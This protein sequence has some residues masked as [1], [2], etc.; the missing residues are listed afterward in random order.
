VNEDSFIKE[1]GRSYIVSSFLP[2]AFFI[3]LLFLLFRVFIPKGFTALVL[4]QW[5]LVSVF[6]IWI[7]FFLFSSVDWIV[8]LFE[9]YHFHPILKKYL[10]NRYSSQLKKQALSYFETQGV[11]RKPVEKRTKKD[12]KIFSENW[13]SAMGELQE[14]ELETSLED[15]V[16]MPTRLGNVMKA[17]E[18]YA[19]DRY[20]IEAITIWPR[21]FS[22]LPSG[23]IKDMEEK[24]NHF[25]FL[26]NS[27]LLIY[28][29][30]GFCLLAAFLGF[31]YQACKYPLFCSTLH[32]L[33]SLQ[34]GFDE[35][36]PLMYLLICA[37]LIYF[38]Y[39]LYRIA[40]NAAQD[41]GLF[42]R[43]GFDLYRME[44]LKQLHRKLPQDLGD[45]R[46]TW[47]ALSTFFISGDRLIWDIEKIKYP[48]Y[49]YHK[50]NNQ[51]KESA[52]TR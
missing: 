48:R 47:L 35:I 2:S 9:G 1:L 39:R 6:T 11:I 23:F 4:G 32:K 12:E 14:L 29:T 50:M 52:K 36:P 25:M 22:V 7:A 46:N 44:L 51:Q 30:S 33:K 38:G 24:N 13:A 17:S 26:L 18:V 20:F 10:C 40:V 43:A 5:V 16:V 15:N 8:K 45:E 27:T 31:F 42:Y 41:F 37:A 34:T 19:Y 21:L 49:Q 3:S 28:V